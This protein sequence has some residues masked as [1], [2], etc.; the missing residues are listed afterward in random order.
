MAVDLSRKS[1]ICTHL[2]VYTDQIHSTF[3][4]HIPLNFLV[5]THFKMKEVINHSGP[6]VVMRDSPIP[7]PDDDHVLIKVIVSGL[8]PKGWKAPELAQMYTEGPMYEMVKPIKDGLNQ[9]DD[10]AGIVE[11]VGANV[12]EFKVSTKVCGSIQKLMYIAW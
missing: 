1:N 4:N 9:G 8:N 6:R 2:I 10:I 7:E 11:K 12:V 5:F 3:E